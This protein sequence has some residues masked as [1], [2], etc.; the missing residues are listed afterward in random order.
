MLV[1]SG[2]VFLLATSESDGRAPTI[3]FD[4]CSAAQQA[5]ITEV[6][7]AVFADREKFYDFDGLKRLSGKRKLEMKRKL[8]KVWPLNIT[9]AASGDNCEYGSNTRGWVVSG[10]AH[11]TLCAYTHPEANYCDTYAGIAFANAHTRN[12]RDSESPGFFGYA[13]QL[14]LARLSGESSE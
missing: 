3:D 13:R 6:Y 4:D 10:N 11:L 9:C 5:K 14:C 7:Q 2:I 12:L 8:V 1:G